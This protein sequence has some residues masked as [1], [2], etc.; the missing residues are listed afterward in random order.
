MLALETLIVAAL[1]FSLLLYAVL[2]GADFGG[3]M[4][5]LLAWGPRA[6]LQREAIAAAIG[7][8]WEAN[9]V[10]LILAV[11]IL[12]TAFP[13]AFAA[14]MTALHIPITL[15]LIGIVLRGSAFVFRKYDAQNDAIHRRW[16]TVFGVASFLTPFF[17]G[18]TLGGLASGE[19]RVEGGIVTTGF[20]RGWLG[21]FALSCGLFAQGLFAF[22]AA[23][24]LAADARRY[25][26]LQEDFRR[27]ALVSGVLLA[28]AAGL[29]FLLAREGAP[30]IFSGLTS[31]WAPLL[32]LWT[33]VLA[34]VALAALWWRRF[35]WARWSA[36]GQVACIILGWGMAQ[37]PYILV[38][39]LTYHETA[40]P[41]ITLRL[42][43]IGL[44]VG[45]VVLIPSLLYLLYIFKL[46]GDGL[47]L[48]E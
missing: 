38:P 39:D 33:S 29:V 9:H 11:V 20:F 31:W 13:V 10:W 26:A 27:R 42:L 44:G 37:Y 5:D 48:E 40:A 28:P 46:H 2:G 8:V 18:L 25:P 30:I 15:I 3:G 43:A 7:P 4:W 35:E 16:S 24:Y 14:I 41:A 22:L 1:F 36:A 19:I 34:V 12:F 21:P 32:L 17:M 45:A 47:A 23:A 6:R